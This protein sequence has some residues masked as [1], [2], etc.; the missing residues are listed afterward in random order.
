MKLAMALLKNKKAVIFGGSRGIGKTIA[1]MFLENGAAVLIAARNAD[2][3]ASTRKE[4]SSV[5]DI[6][7]FVADVSNV[8]EIDRAAQE[9][10]KIFGGVHIL[11]NGAGVYGP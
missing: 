1:R 6:H 9:A 10:K 8:Q 5:G 11:V 7:S 3:L 2:E 4:L